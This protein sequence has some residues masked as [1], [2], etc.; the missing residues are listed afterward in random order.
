MSLWVLRERKRDLGVGAAIEDGGKKKGDSGKRYGENLDL[1]VC[2]TIYSFIC[3]M[4]T[5][6]FLIGGC[7]TRFYTSSLLNLILRTNSFGVLVQI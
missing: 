7:K 5:W 3:K 4:L 2:G 1:I 6:H